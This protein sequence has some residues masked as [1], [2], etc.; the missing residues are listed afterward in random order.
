MS[1]LNLILGVPG[2]GSCY[3]QHTVK[4][5]NPSYQ[6]PALPALELALEYIS[7]QLFTHVR[8][9]G[10]AYGANIY[11]S[12]NKGVISFSA[13]RSSNLNKAYDTFREVLDN[14]TSSND[15]WDSDLLDS[16]RGGMIFEMTSRESTYSG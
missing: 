14:H 4:M 3:L 7:K 9:E 13:Y 5:D 6:N 2:D 15:H 12:V 16:A 11:V 1:S 8:G 10:L